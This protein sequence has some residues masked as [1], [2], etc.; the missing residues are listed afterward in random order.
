MLE[1]HN[2]ATAYARCLAAG[3]CL[4]ILSS[5]G[6][7]GGSTPAPPP[8]TA[9]RFTSAASASVVENTAAPFYRATASDPQNDPVS[10]TIWSGADATSFVIDGDGNLRFASAPNFDRPTDSN[11]NNVYEVVLRASAGGE[12]VDL[13]LQVTVTNSVEG[14]SVKRVA[15]GLVEPVGMASLLA[16]GK[17]VVAEKG[18]RVLEFDDASGSLTPIPTVNSAK[19]PGEIL[20]VHFGFD[21]SPYAEG[22]LL[23]SHSATDGLLLQSV[24]RN[25]SRSFSRQLAGPWSAPVKAS[26]FSSNRPNQ[27]GSVLAAI[28]DPSGN[29]AQVAT[30]GYGKLWE[31][32]AADPYAGA[33]LPSGLV[34]NVE[35]IGDGLHA[36]SGGGIFFNQTMLFDQGATREHEMNLFQYNWRPLDFGWPFYEGSKAVRDNPP[37]AVN[38]PSLVY[39][40]GSGY[41]EGTGI[42]AG[43]GYSGAIAGIQGHFVFGDKNGKIWSIPSSVLNNGFLHLGNELED[44]SLDFTPDAGKIDSPVEFVIA[45]QTIYILDSDGEIFRVG[46]A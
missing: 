37:A 29:L 41:R 8:L 22:V 2:K 39:G 16:Q 42:I 40:V 1:R 13:P 18:G 7:G 20:D 17:F 5:C 30:S 38:G 36:P 24:S 45:F 14:I 34:Y 33:S 21:G 6:G 28:G 35:T 27:G 43:V 32:L 46:P 9:P 19:R 25:S 26:L 3:A 23:L 4:G 11:N 44:R 10:I 15:S 31:I 12:V